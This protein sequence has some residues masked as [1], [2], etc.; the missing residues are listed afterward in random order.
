[1]FC[2]AAF[3]QQLLYAGRALR[4]PG[5]AVLPHDDEESTGSDSRVV[6]EAYQ[7]HTLSAAEPERGREDDEFPD[8]IIPFPSIFPALPR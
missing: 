3:R 5:A 2:V 6:V 8:N 7:T 4:P 1:M